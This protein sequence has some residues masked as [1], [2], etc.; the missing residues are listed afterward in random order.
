MNVKTFPDGNDPNNPVRI[1]MD[2]VFDMFH[3]GHARLLKQGK[4]KFKHVHLIVGV[5]LQEDVEK[6]KGITLSTRYE[7]LEAIKHCKWADEIVDAPWV[8]TIEFMDS[9]NAHYVA[10]DSEPYPYM[11]IADLYAPI[12]EAGRFL[13]TTRTEGISTTDIIMRV[14]RDYE[15]YVKRNVKRGC[16]AEELNIT[17]EKYEEVKKQIALDEE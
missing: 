5:C 12:K 9:I 2:G 17:K 13:P 8:T 7:R 16:T 14:I 4:E 6:N 15:F 1:Y 3:H 10:R 11:D